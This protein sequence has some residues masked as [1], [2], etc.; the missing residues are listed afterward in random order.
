MITICSRWETSQ[1]PPELEWR[2]W[3]QLREPFQINRFIF[4]PIV[5]E[6]HGVNILD[7]YDTM[8]EALENLAGPK[9]FMEPTGDKYL[10]D[11]N[12]SVDDDLILVLGK[13]EISN[14]HLVG[15]NDFAVKIRSPIHGNDI[16]GICIASIVLAHRY[17]Q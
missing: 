6:M 15:P 9:V 8:E 4:T 13:T 16:Y 2:M 5:H 12:L 10:S 17:G 11:L 3:M 1:M 14:A 7:Q